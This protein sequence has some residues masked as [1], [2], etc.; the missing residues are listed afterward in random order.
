MARTTKAGKKGRTSGTA[1]RR[2]RATGAKKAVRATKERPA[3]KKAPRAA[4]GAPKAK[5]PRYDLAQRM[6]YIQTKNLPRLS[7]RP[8]MANP[9]HVAR[10]A[11]RPVVPW[12]ER[13]PSLLWI[14]MVVVMAALALLIYS[15]MK[16]TPPEK[17]EE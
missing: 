17:T 5:A 11:P 3:G 8:R 6:R 15:L 4:E 7:L 10:V 9:N 14:V 12:T 16:K 13:H 1:T 2:R